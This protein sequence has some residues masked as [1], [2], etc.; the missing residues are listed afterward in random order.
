MRNHGG[1]MRR[2]SVHAAVCAVMA[3]GLLTA[4]SGRAPASAATPTCA[5]ETA[6]AAAAARMANDCDRRVEVTSQRTGTTQVYANPDG[7]STVVQSAYP[8]RVRRSDGSWSALDPTLAVAVD[9]TLAPKA[10]TVAVSFSGGGS[11]EFVRVRRD[12]GEVALSW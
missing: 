11:S 3:A 1:S 10:S 2:R 12:G 8:Q 7:T 9:G 5:P 4:P 6:Q